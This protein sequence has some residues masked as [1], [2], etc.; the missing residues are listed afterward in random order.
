MQARYEFKYLLRPEV[1][2]AVRERAAIWLDRDAMAGDDGAYQ[3]TSLYLDST[4][5]MLARQTLEG[6]RERFKLRLR[7]YGDEPS[8]VFAEVKQRVGKSIAKWRAIVDTKT[9]EKLAHNEPVPE[10]VF[11]DDAA[12]G[13]AAGERFRQFVD[14]VDARPRLWVRYRREA[15]TSPWGD[16]SRLTFDHKLQVQEPVG[17]AFMPGP[18]WSWV[19]LPRPVILELKFNDAYPEWMRSVAEGLGLKRLSCSKYAQGAEVVGGLPWAIDR[20]GTWMPG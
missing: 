18:N 15:F 17:H 8:R 20:R 14:M 2:D 4:E 9:A 11:S 19:P 1:A 6:V 5:W 16:G 13:A 3:V 7:F 10:G 12:Y